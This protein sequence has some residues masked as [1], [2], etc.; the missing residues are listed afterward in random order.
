M[1]QSNHQ[2]KLKL[3]LE[4][5]NKCGINSLIALRSSNYYSFLD[6]FFGVPPIVMVSIVGILEGYNGDTQTTEPFFLTKLI[7]SPICALFKAV[8]FQCEFSNK[9]NSFKNA[10]NEY[11]S[12]KRDIE[13]Y[14]TMN[15]S[16]SDLLAKINEIKKRIET[17]KKTTPA[18]PWLVCRHFDEER[19]IINAIEVVNQVD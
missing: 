6:I 12:V 18:P 17:I 11:L 13:M 2:Q 9:S 16:E 3:L 14:Q 7:L 4:W 15:F 1:L 19:E 8:H 10:Y 5:K